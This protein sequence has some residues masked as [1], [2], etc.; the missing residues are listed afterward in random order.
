MNLKPKDKVVDLATG[1][2]AV[3]IAT[4]T[5]DNGAK[6]ASIKLE[7]DGSKWVLVTPETIKKN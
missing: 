4:H 3:V 2:N 1:S 7:N 6:A 5:Y